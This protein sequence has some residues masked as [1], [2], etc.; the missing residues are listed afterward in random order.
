[1]PFEVFIQPVSGTTTI[2]E[3]NR[4]CL[5]YSKNTLVIEKTKH[6][7][8]K[9]HFVKDRVQLGTIKLRYMSTRDMVADMLTKPLLGHELVKHRS[10]I[11]GTSEPM[12]RYNP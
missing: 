6:I 3:D 9:Y 10:A 11:L 4:S 8:L 2:W 7:D 5:A 12:Q 1:M